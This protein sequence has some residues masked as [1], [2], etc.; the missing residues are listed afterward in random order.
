MYAQCQIVCTAIMTPRSRCCTLVH[1]FFSLDNLFDIRTHFNF[2][3]QEAMC[4]DDLGVH[5][6]A[7]CDAKQLSVCYFKIPFS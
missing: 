1:L 3:H 7:K 5:S 4:V 6:D 2:C